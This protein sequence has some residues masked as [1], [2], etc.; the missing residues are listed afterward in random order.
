MTTWHGGWR[1]DGRIS[2]SVEARNHLDAESD[3]L[4]KILVELSV[5]TR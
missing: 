1:A 5:L 2:N 3:F 4:R